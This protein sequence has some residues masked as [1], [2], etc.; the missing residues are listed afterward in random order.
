MTPLFQLY[1]NGV[2]N[3]VILFQIYNP[4]S[5]LSRYVSN[6]YLV[7]VFPFHLEF[8]AFQLGLLFCDGLVNRIQNKD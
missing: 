1:T 2:K 5:F 7:V 8:C 6:G 3:M 4:D